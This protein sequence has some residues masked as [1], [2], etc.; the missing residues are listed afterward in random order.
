MPEPPCGSSPNTPGAPHPFSKAESYRE[1][2]F[3][4]L[5]QSSRSFGLDP[6]L[7]TIGG[8]WNVDRQVSRELCFLPQ[9]FLQHTNW[10]NACITANTTSTLLSISC[11]IL[12]SFMNDTPRHLNYST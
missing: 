11:V 10:N 8:G 12:S 4:C 6:Y 1:A 3:F 5:Y 9:L 2:N 7:M